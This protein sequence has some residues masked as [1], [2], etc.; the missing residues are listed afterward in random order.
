[1]KFRNRNPIALGTSADY[2]RLLMFGLFFLLP[3]VSMSIDVDHPN[4]ISTSEALRK[5]GRILKDKSIFVFPELRENPIKWNDSIPQGKI[6]NY[7]IEKPFLLAA[8]PNEYYVYQ[9][10]VWALNKDVED[11]KIQFSDFKDNSGAT[12]SLTKMTCFNKEGIDF[13]GESFLK[14]VNVSA[15]KVQALWVGID[16]EGIEK[17]SYTGSVSVTVGNEK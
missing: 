6:K 4:N 1:M 16:L 17:G 7:S 13:K 3:M 5:N 2:G 15:G 9:L 11:I 14:N 8:Q 10:G 12:I